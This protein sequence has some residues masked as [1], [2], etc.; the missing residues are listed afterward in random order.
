LQAAQKPNTTHKGRLKILE[1][2]PRAK[3]SCPEGM[4]LPQTHYNNPKELILLKGRNT[5]EDGINY[6]PIV[7]VKPDAVYVKS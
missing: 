4:A 6:K 7:A 1:D 5:K 3:M 2:Q